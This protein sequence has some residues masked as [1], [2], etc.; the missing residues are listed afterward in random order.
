MATE[1][2]PGTYQYRRNC[3]DAL[4]FFV[5]FFTFV[6]FL[7]VVAFFMTRESK[8]KTP[9]KQVEIK[10]PAAENVGKQVGSSVTGFGKGFVDGAKERLNHKE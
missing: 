4:D 3:D 9:P 8:P 1:Y 5:G 2:K 10:V 7:A 6:A